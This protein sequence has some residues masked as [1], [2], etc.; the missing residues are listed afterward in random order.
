M[1]VWASAFRVPESPFGGLGLKLGRTAVWLK[2][3]NVWLGSGS[4]DLNESV[5]PKI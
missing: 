2:A 3:R 5:P 1:V 4:L